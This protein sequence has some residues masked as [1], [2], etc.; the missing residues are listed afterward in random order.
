ML[1]G[2]QM[3]HSALQSGKWERTERLYSIY[4]KEL[5]ASEGREN[6]MKCFE[7]HSLEASGPQEPAQVRLLRQ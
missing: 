2:Y 3:M 6:T 4:S 7:S 1:L 5:L